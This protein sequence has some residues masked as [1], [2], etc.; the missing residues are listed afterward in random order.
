MGGNGDS[1]GPNSFRGGI[2]YGD[3]SITWEAEGEPARDLAR[4]GAFGA[5]AVLAAAAVA[6][7]LHYA[8]KTRTSSA[9][10]LAE[11]ALRRAEE[12]LAALQPAMK[13]ED[14]ATA[15]AAE[16]NLDEK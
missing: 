15:A 4:A 1:F 14:V 2:S 8:K 3:T 16:A 5:G 11:E 10:L 7:G 12:R 6:A 13:A 9:E